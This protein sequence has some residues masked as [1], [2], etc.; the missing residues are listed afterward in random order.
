MP[1]VDNTVGTSTHKTGTENDICFVFNNWLDDLQKFIRVI[2]QVSILNDYDIPGSGSNTA[3]K[4][5]ALTL[6][7]CVVDD[8]GDAPRAL[9]SPL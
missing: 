6:V 2:F 3:P 5:R 9:D 8:F 4:G 1:E 7:S